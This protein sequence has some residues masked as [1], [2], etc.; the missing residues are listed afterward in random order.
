MGFSKKEHYKHN[1][2]ALR[3]AF[4]LEQEKRQATKTERQQMMLYSGFG[5]L[6]FVPNP[7]R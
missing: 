2:E 4:R 5:G 3:I 1:I 7:I 6:K